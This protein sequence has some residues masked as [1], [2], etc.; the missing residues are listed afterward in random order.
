[1]PL[2]V[3]AGSVTLVQQGRC[4]TGT[5]I[6]SL[7]A[8]SAAAQY[9]KLPDTSATSDG[10]N[11]VSYDPP[12]CYYEGG[13]LKFNGGGNIGSCSNSDQCVCSAAGVCVRIVWLCKRAVGILSV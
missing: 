1:M 3:V 9:L 5:E 6:T 2:T 7:S 4:P 10:Q 12:F 13:E 8:C 11:G